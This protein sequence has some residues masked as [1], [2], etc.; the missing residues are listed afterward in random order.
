MLPTWRAALSGLKKLLPT[1]TAAEVGGV[2]ANSLNWAG[3]GRPV[4]V[5]LTCWV[6]LEPT[7]SLVLAIPFAS[8]VLC[9]GF[10]A[11]APALDVTVH[12]T[13]TLGTGRPLTSSTVTLN[14]IGSGLL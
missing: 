12:V 4:T 5:A 14:G 1:V 3:L 9:A 2:V 11:P 13:T 8:V 6:V 10:T 7:E